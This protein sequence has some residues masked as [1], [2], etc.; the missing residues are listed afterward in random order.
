MVAVSKISFG[1]QPPLYMDECMWH[2]PSQSEDKITT[3]IASGMDKLSKLAESGCKSSSG[4]RHSCLV[5]DL[6]GKALSFS[7]V[8]V[9]LVVGFL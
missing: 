5:P 9:K 8:N 1:I 4:R 6:S 2:R 7:S 3:A